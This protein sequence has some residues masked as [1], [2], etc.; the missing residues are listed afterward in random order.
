MIRRNRMLTRRRVLGAGL[1]GLLPA[2]CRPVS[3]AP[4]GPTPEPAGPTIG[5]PNIAPLLVASPG[6]SEIARP[7]LVE[8]TRQ[9]PSLLA[10]WE[11]VEGDFTAVLEARLAT[12]SAPDVVRVREGQI[13]RWRHAGLLA[14]FGNDELFEQLPA[15][16]YAGARAGT[17]D[18]DGVPWGVP[19]YHDAMFLAYNS[20]HLGRVGGRVPETLEELAGFARELQA[21]HS[22][23]SPVS[24]NL[25]PK[26]NANLPWWGLLKAAAVS[27]EQTEAGVSEAAAV[28]DALRA[29]VVEDGTLDPGIER[30][31]YDRLA[32][33]DCAFAIVGAYSG[34]RLQSAGAPIAFAPLPGVSGPGRRS[35]CWTPAFALASRPQPHPAGARLA[36]HL[37]SIDKSGE[38]WGPRHFA[39]S[40]SLPPAYPGLLRDS[41]VSAH[42]RRWVDP[43]VLNS[44]LEQAAPV[45][46]LWQP[47]FQ[48]WEHRCQELV[49][50]A[51]LGQT[52]PVA[53]A[54][55]MWSDAATYGDSTDS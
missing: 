50:D 54:M 52:E 14:G 38:F 39:L 15:L 16:L 6:D 2:A 4:S 40:G 29:M 33:G 35:V 41:S 26:A 47:W 1:A 28:L 51:V 7:V 11:K 45:E 31:D 9:N 42:F 8:F 18:P 48:P 23:R 30:P 53:A 55:Q 10:R 22:L 49:M 46:F 36:V 43:G 19:H 34:P 17:F 27:F 3:D 44:V 12:A 32:D 25:A 5:D 24:I 37:G 13:G 20:A 21:R